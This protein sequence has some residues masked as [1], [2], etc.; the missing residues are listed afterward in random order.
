[1]IA[2]IFTN[3]TVKSE[4]VGREREGRKIKWTNKQ[5]LTVNTL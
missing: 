1:M 5:N 2:M 4:E 3:I